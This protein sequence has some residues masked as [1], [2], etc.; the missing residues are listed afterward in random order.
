L[1]VSE[2]ILNA[3]VK[4]KKIDVNSASELFYSSKTFRDIA[5]KDTELYKQGWETIY[6]MLFPLPTPH[7]LLPKQ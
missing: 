3:L 7:S 5:N 2:N 1:Q 4:D 6:K